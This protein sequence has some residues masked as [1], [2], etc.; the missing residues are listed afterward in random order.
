MPEDANLVK[1]G[2]L[3]NEVGIERGFVTSSPKRMYEFNKALAG[4]MNGIWKIFPNIAGAR[5]GLG[6]EVD[7]E[8]APL[9]DGANNK[10]ERISGLDSTFQ[11]TGI[12]SAIYKIEAIRN[13]QQKTSYVIVGYSGQEELSRIIE[14]N[15]E[16][17]NELLL[18]LFA[19]SGSP[20]NILHLPSLG[21]PEQIFNLP[22]LIGQKDY[23]VDAN[24][25]PFT[26]S[27]GGSRIRYDLATGE[28][29]RSDIFISSAH[30]RKDAS[31]L[32]LST[33]AIMAGFLANEAY[34]N[35]IDTYR[36]TNRLGVQTSRYEVGSTGADWATRVQVTQNVPNAFFSAR[37]LD[38]IQ[39]LAE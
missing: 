15:P 26:R 16:A 13:N 8:P 27:A 30:V 2:E 9:R 6:I 35:A 21:M 36:I 39:K 1:A 3:L 34:G 17:A 28:A 7:G 5:L 10:P 38:L 24:D 11:D 37:V 4:S 33:K 12:P 23:L 20:L 32:G 18:R 31:V 22:E 14:A 19:H 29:K 25:L